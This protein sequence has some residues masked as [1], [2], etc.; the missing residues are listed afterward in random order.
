MSQDSII[1]LL[2]KH[3]EGLSAE[4]IYKKLGISKQTTFRALESLRNFKEVAFKVIRHGKHG[5]YRTYTYGPLRVRKKWL[6]EVKIN[7]KSSFDQT[8]EVQI[9]L[10]NQDIKKN[11]IRRI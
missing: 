7:T 5:I 11:F 1:K 9:F 4:Q 6:K 10:D 2:N 3:P 8:R